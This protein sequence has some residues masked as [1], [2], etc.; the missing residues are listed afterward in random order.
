[1]K[2]SP[3]RFRRRV[4][5][6]CSK[7][8]WCIPVVICSTGAAGDERTLILESVHTDTP[9]SLVARWRRVPAMNAPGCRIW[10]KEPVYQRKRARSGC[11]SVVVLLAS[12]QVRAVKRTFLLCYPAAALLISR[13]ACFN[14][15]GVSSWPESMR[16]TSRVR[17]AR[18]SSSIPATVRPLLSCFS[19]Q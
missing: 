11:A 15:S 9:S 5:S 3:L 1:M 17:P 8:S 16:P 6:A 10:R 2:P 14:A 7:I 18:S 13:S 19:T 12:P 4:L